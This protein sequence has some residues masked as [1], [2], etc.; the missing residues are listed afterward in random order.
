M[1]EEWVETDNLAAMLQLGFTLT[2]PSADAEK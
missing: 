1:V 2:P